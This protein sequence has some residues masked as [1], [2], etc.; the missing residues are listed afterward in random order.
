[1][2]SDLFS[3]GLE[4]MVYGMGT[5]LAFLSMLICATLL[6]SFLVRR[7]EPEV[8]PAEPVAA[9]AA[10]DPQVL[11]VITAAIHQHRSRP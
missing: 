8:L 11:A 10:T 1:M 3:Q 4:L 5:V 2:E 9:S 6:M 7:F